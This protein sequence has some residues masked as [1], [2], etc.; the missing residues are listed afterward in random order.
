MVNSTP[1]RSVSNVSQ[2]DAPETSTGSS[3]DDSTKFVLNFRISNFATLEDTVKSVPYYRDHTYWRIMAMR[4]HNENNKNKESKKEQ[5]RNSDLTLGIF[6]HCTTDSYSDDWIVDAQACLRIL[7]LANTGTPITRELMGHQYTVSETDW[8]YSTFAKWMEIVDEN[9]G[10]LVDGAIQIQAEITAKKPVNLMDYHTFWRK[11]TDLLKIAELQ[12]ERGNV[13]KAIEANGRSAILCGKRCFKLKKQIDEQKDRLSQ[14]AISENIKR[15]ESMTSSGC[16]DLKSASTSALKQAISTTSIKKVVNKAKHFGYQIPGVRNGDVRSSRRSSLQTKS[17]G[18]KDGDE[19]DGCTSPS[20]IYSLSPQSNNSSA[21]ANEPCSYHDNLEDNTVKSAQGALLPETSSGPQSRKSSFSVYGYPNGDSLKGDSSMSNYN[22]QRLEVV[23]QEARIEYE[24]YQDFTTKTV[25]RNT[26]DYPVDSQQTIINQNWSNVAPIPAAFDNWE[27][28]LVDNNQAL[29]S[30]RT[31]KLDKPHPMNFLEPVCYTMKN[32]SRIQMEEKDMAPKASK[33]MENVI[34]NN[35]HNYEWWPE[36]PEGQTFEDYHKI[37]KVLCI[38]ERVKEQEDMAKLS[39]FLKKNMIG[40]WKS[41]HPDLNQKGKNFFKLLSDLDTRMSQFKCEPND[42]DIQNM[43]D[44]KQ[45]FEE[46]IN[47]AFIEACHLL[48]ANANETVQRRFF[49]KDSYVDEECFDDKYLNSEGTYMLIPARICDILAHLYSRWKW[50]EVVYI[51]KCILANNVNE[52]LN[53]DLKDTVSEKQKLTTEISLLNAENTSLKENIKTLKCEIKNWIEKCKVNESAIESNKTTSQLYKNVLKEFN[54]YKKTSE[55]EVSKLKREIQSVNDL[56]KKFQT[57]Y[58]LL[59]ESYKNLQKTTEEKYNLVKKLEKQLSDQKKSSEKETTSLQERCKRLELNLLEKITDNGLIY[60][61]KS[62]E[63]A[64]NEL[65]TWKEK[66]KEKDYLNDEI[67]K[68][69]IKIFEEYISTIEKQITSIRNDFES[70][71]GQINSGKNLSQIGKLKIPKPPILP[72][73]EPL[74]VPKKK[75]TPPKSNIQT[76]HK[77]I[78]NPISMINYGPTSRGLSSTN[79][80]FS[81]NISEKSAFRVPVS[82]FSKDLPTSSNNPAYSFN[83]IINPSYENKNMRSETSSITPIGVK[84]A[85][86]KN[87]SENSA[88]S[89]PKIN[90]ITKDD[91]N[92]MPDFSTDKPDNIW[93]VWNPLSSTNEITSLFHESSKPIKDNISSYEFNKDPFEY[94]IN[95]DPI[96]NIWAATPEDVEV[97]TLLKINTNF[98][99]PPKDVVKNNQGVNFNAMYDGVQGEGG[100]SNNFSPYSNTS[101]STNNYRALQSF[102]GGTSSQNDNMSGGDWY[103]NSIP[104]TQN[105]RISTFSN[106]PTSAQGNSNNHRYISK[107]DSVSKIQMQSS[108]QQAPQQQPTQGQYTT[109]NSQQQ[110]TTGLQKANFSQPPPTNNIWDWQNTNY[111]NTSNGSYQ[112]QRRN[113]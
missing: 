73:A 85:N 93:G 44:N 39:E 91:N 46:T 88:L 8:G 21:F 56:K 52:E 26:D 10:Y 7:N 72:K 51:K 13:D 29:F 59:Q 108:L 63:I 12:L 54:G 77:T 89:T 23:K 100:L 36:V 28:K 9:N 19:D 40:M 80:T 79:P 11:G 14:V 43:I 90:S 18:S 57:D 64:E 30:F 38:E 101:S 86:F 17:N 113:Y 49:F 76:P 42:E 4:R 75:S 15:I 111:T 48:N 41:R 65:N 74:P 60:Y 106:K 82:T 35:D 92:S 110:D 102:G 104:W 62:K 32:C 94:S 37:P 103:N 107:S 96:S 61:E 34:Y 112:S 45:G 83:P 95:N 105:N 3:Y 16:S 1:S 109:Y 2:S 31:N 53:K 55:E 87:N 27:Q 81:N 68:N 70:R 22:S 66:Q 98:N 6:V 69:N 25:L 5:Y 97:S 99:P 58:N 50:I 33:Y 20:F 71:T 84:P 67:V 78:N 24:V 47:H